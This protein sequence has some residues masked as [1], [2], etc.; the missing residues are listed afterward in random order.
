MIADLNLPG[1]IAY[2]LGYREY[3][4]SAGFV[5]IDGSTPTLSNFG[6]SKPASGYPDKGCATTW[7]GNNYEWNDLS[8]TDIRRAI[9]KISTS[10]A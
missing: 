5:E 10:L 4:E 6:S 1:D 8:C 3:S 7:I 9:C 2:W